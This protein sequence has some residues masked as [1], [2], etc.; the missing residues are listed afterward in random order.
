MRIDK[1]A[2]LGWAIRDRRRA[3]GFTQ[4]DL[5][6]AAGVSRRWI[7]DLEAGRTTGQLSLILRVLAELDLVLD[8]RP[9]NRSPSAERVDLDEHLR[10]F[11]A[12]ADV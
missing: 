9:V 7:L 12:S 11:G 10:G 1:P 2:D 6:A 4:A 3:L 8:V 5:A